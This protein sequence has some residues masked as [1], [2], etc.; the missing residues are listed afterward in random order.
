M[1]IIF[2]LDIINALPS[3]A[4]VYFFYDKN[5]IL[6][7]IGKSVNIKQRVKQHFFGKDRKSIKIQ[8]FTKKIK[9]EI[10]GSELIA[11]LLES[12][13]IKEFQPIYNRA[14]RKAVFMFGL[15]LKDYNNYKALVVDRIR[16]NEA[17]ITSFSSVKE[18]K[19][20]LFAITDKYH[21]CQKING[22][23]RTSGPCFQYQIK[24]CFGACIGIENPE[25]YNSRVL[26][27]VSNN[28]IKNFTSFFV[29]KGRTED[30]KGIVYI[31]NGVYKGFGFCPIYE[32][33]SNY[34][35]YI[36]SKKDNK[37]VRRI[38]IRHLISN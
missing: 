20:I 9:Y 35:K 32:I 30:E 23:Y 21:L 12:E 27:F 25:S 34:E 16:E 2:P 37:D 33:E 15:Y 24:Q 10:T 7:Y 29:V 6:I 22:L 8:T 3:V 19:D 31:K 38:L 36:I 4:G 17:E 14:Q 13:L 5:D 18:A 28:T 11:L 26:N 1:D